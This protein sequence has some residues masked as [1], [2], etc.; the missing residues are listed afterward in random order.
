M[1]HQ[2]IHKYQT[3]GIMSVLLLLVF[4]LAYFNFPIYLKLIR[5]IGIF[6]TF[7][8]SMNIWVTRRFTIN[9]YFLFL[10]IAFFFVSFLDL[11]NLILDSLQSFKPY[12]EHLSLLLLCLTNLLLGVVFLIGPYINQRRLSKRQIF[13]IFAAIATVYLGVMGNLLFQ[14]EH[15][16]PSPRQISVLLIVA[17]ILI[18]G[19]LVIHRKR[20]FEFD[21][22]IFENILLC[23]AF[24][25][26]SMIL[27]VFYDS[28][29][30]L[31]KIL[32][33]FCRMIALFFMYEAAITMVLVKPYHKLEKSEEALRLSETR[34][35]AVFEG[36][37][38][39]VVL[40]DS[41]G[42]IIETNP[43]VEEMFGHNKYYLRNMNLADITFRDDLETGNFMFCEL[44]SGKIN[45]YH[46]ENRFV[47]S[48]GGLL[49][50]SVTSSVLR[51]SDNP[52]YAIVMI[53]DITKN[54]LME[55]EL[56]AEKER[57]SVTLRSIGDGV[58]ATDI[59][60]NIILMNKA[61]E[62]ITGW[63]QREVFERSLYE[64][65]YLINDQTSEPYEDIHAEIIKNSDILQFNDN[66]I[67][68]DRHLEER[69]LILSGSPIR[70]TNGNTIGV[71]L[72]FRDITEKRKIEDELFKAA[73]LDS[74]G[75]LAGGIAHDFNNILAEILA[76]VQL[77]HAFYK[78]D[79]DIT[80][81]LRDIEDAIERA[82]GLTKQLLTFAKGGAPIK[83]TAS[84]SDLIRDNVEFALRGTNVNCEFKLAE[85]L[86]SVEVDQGQISQVINNLIINAYQAMPNGGTIA[87]QAENL[88]VKRDTVIPTGKYIKLSVADRGSGIPDEYLHKIFDPYFTTKPGGSGL[89][90]ATSYSIIKR[91]DGHIEV[92]PNEGQGTIFHIY[93]PASESK[94]YSKEEET[95]LYITGDGKVLLMDD[96]L[97]IRY[98]IGQML[99]YIGY[100]VRSAQ[101]GDELLELY[102]RA[103]EAGDPF[104]V[105]ILDLTIPGG[106]GGRETINELLKID[107]KCKAIVSSGYSNDPIM[108]DYLQYGFCGVVSKPYKINELAEAINRVNA[109]KQLKL[110][111]DA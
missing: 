31:T 60:G 66:V 33:P 73:K 56:A 23:L 79:R 35:S 5:S 20:R 6:L 26:I 87:V 81:Y 50:G 77:A 101:D 39:G 88:T 4:P 52:V 19:S 67:L 17:L 65:F 9:R 102:R 82:T 78:R 30:L 99:E 36:A 76:N 61:A 46:L 57:L 94:V 95:E 14:I 108:A 10:G 111:L 32:M 25:G 58:I 110:A 24:L 15:G 85:D 109:K 96:D 59:E 38:V 53:E 71:V 43:S 68:V 70:N 75:V 98:L 8:F 18:V 34:F 107:P 27:A 93:L 62:E 41:Q 12:Q 100:R 7:N 3:L 11:F 13:G 106:K 40:V 45:K 16:I 51:D 44:M 28:I 72:V 89:G 74:L 83:K 55:E 91:H 2:P 49:W 84:I 92:E 54:K 104:D 103:M 29:N 97:N 69:A 80:K 21:A 63:S 47:K 42:Q 1:K 86:W 64:I 105:V 37:G 48:D 90:L 22:I